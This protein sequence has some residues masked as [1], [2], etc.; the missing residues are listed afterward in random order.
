MCSS[1]PEPRS[2]VASSSSTWKM[3]ALFDI[4]IST[5]TARSRPGEIFTSS[6]AYADSEWMFWW[7]V[8]N[9]TRERPRAMSSASATRTTPASTV[10]GAPLRRWPL[11]A[12]S[13]SE[14]MIVRSGSS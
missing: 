3:P 14:E 5:L 12:C 8:S 1:S 2:F 7:P 9:G 4:E 11:I 10:S 13:A 6:I